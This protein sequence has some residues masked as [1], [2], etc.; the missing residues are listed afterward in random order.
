MAEP[1]PAT[2]RERA[3]TDLSDAEL[4]ARVAEA[5]GKPFQARQIRH[6]LYRHGATDWEGCKNVPARLRADLA[7]RLSLRASRLVARD[8]AADGTEKLLLELAD[9]ETIETVVI[10]EG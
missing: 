3:A 9:G 7:E 1:E 6:W 4:D 10:P 2:D 8:A 5:G